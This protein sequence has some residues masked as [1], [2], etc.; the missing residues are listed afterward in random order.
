MPIID[1]KKNKIIKNY[2]IEELRVKAAQMRA[3]SMIALTAAGSGHSGGTLSIMDI[4]AALYLKSARHDPLNPEWPDRDRIFWS[5]GHKAPALYVALG[6]AGYFPVEDTV[7]LRK[8]WSGFEGHPNSLKLPGV[9]LSSGS[10]GQG[11]GVAV[12]SA[13]ESKLSGRDNNI[14]C[15][16]GDGEH[17]E[18][19]VWEA[20]M[21]AAHYKLDNLIAIVDQ[22]GLQIDG[23]TDEVMC[24]K[25]LKDKYESFCWNVITLD[26]HNMEEIIQAFEQADKIKGAPTVIIA[27]TIKGK[28]VSYAENQVNYH[29]ISPKGGRR[30]EESLEKALED[31]KAPGISE[32]KVDKMLESARKY[33]EEVDKKII[34]SLPKFSR[35]Y[36]W[37]RAETMKTDMEP[38][39][40]GFGK[41]LEEIGEDERS[42]ALGCD[43]SNSVRIDGFYKNNPE[44]KNRFF[45][46]GIAEANATLV[47][48]GL[49]KEGRTP[50][51]GS[52]GVFST[53]RNWDQLRNTVCTNK[54]NVKISAGHAGI[55]VGPDGQTHQALEEIAVTNYIPN[56]IVASPC[57]A[58]ETHKMT[59]A[60]YKIK[61]PSVI[62]YARESSAV[63]TN[64]DTPFKFGEALIV[65]YRK[66]KENFADAF[67][68]YSA[69]EYEN[70]NEDI[71][72]IACGPIFTEAMRAA[73]ILKEEYGIES[74]II[75]V[76]TIK[77]LDKGTIVKAAEETNAVL[78]CE[79]HQ[80]G[81]FG[82]IIAGAVFTLKNYETPVIMDMVGVEDKFGESGAPWELMIYFQIVAESIAEKARLLID[83]KK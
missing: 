80:K 25:S 32:E 17:N 60:L 83:K 73:W 41:A 21:C 74:R 20:I 30:G 3:Y 27:D 75:N 67:E 46:I 5:V 42:V 70:E 35:D 79:E 66:E 51:M 76:H 57:D 26:G 78:S 72:I 77:P 64:D 34:K 71:S 82:N 2:T 28:G 31:I 6:M 65:R 37:N 10:L 81:G 62:R 1:S 15:I 9:E 54:Y 69:K 12:G 50:F 39:R 4:A 16:M 63:V 45:S 11:L 14:F 53:G 22:N 40:N 61:G 58:V 59:H 49:A 36:W 48:A 44:R 68:W 18:G 13:L 38:T 33:Q 29:G 56:L 8:L 47:A 7:K 55:S 23:T 52:Y 43:I 19:S 24:L